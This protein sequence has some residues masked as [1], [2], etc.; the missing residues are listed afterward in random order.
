MFYICNKI[1][2]FVIVI[3]ICLANLGI[4]NAKDEFIENQLSLDLAMEAAAEAVK[5]C[6]AHGW[7]V[8]ASVVDS[9]GDVKV[10]AKGDHS[11]PHTKDTSFRKAYTQVTM[12]PIF[13]FDALSI[14][15][16]K[17][18]GNPNAAALATIPNI[19]VLPG[20]VAIKIKGAIVAAIGVGGAPGGDKDEA[21]AMK[22]LEK[23]KDRLPQ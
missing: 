13:G 1:T 21:C 15:I 23:I 18:K 16:E 7:N 14:W 5:S 22:G 3:V 4:A 20:A 8:S 6:A 11:T 17:L 2:G 9:S 19:I 12:G 10:Q